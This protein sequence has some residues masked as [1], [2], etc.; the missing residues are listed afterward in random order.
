MAYKMITTAERGWFFIQTDQAQIKAHNQPGP[1]IH[2]VAA[3]ALTEDGEVVGLV[4]CAHHKRSGA[5]EGRDTYLHRPNANANGEYKHF[6]DFTQAE[7]ASLS[8]PV[9]PNQA[10]I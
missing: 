3:W 8:N 5:A 2:R 6:N 4:G 7:L 10:S 9:R 1:I